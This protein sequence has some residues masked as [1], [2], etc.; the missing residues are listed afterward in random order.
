[1]S[2][3]TTDAD[4][5]TELNPPPNHFKRLLRQTIGSELS[6]HEV[7]LAHTESGWTINVFPSGLL[8]AENLL[9]PGRYFEKGPV[10]IDE[11]VRLWS[12]LAEGKIVPI[13]KSG[14][15]RKEGTP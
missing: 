9:E 3:Y 4:G 2:Y 5:I 1:M 7:W 15:I 13:L 14:W 6:I 11:A 8:I 10:T 12:L